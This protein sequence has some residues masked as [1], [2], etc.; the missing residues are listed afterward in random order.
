[1]N[2]ETR[3]ECYGKIETHTEDRK[4]VEGETVKSR[5]SASILGNPSSFAKVWFM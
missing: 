1:M 4:K 5:Y 3:K 2:G